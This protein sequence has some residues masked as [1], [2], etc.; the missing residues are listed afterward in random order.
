MIAQPENICIEIQASLTRSGLFAGADDSSNLGNSWRVSPKPFFLSSENAEFFHQLG[1][2]LLK[3]YTAWNK[4]YL[5]SV[6]GTK[7]FAQYLDAGKPRSWSSLA[8]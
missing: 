1:P 8:E 7:W 6:K 4:L 2:H 5:E 3:F